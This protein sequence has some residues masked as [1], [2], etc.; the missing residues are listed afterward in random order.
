M[1]CECY[2]GVFFDRLCS[3]ILEMF[4]PFW[5]QRWS[6]PSGGAE[7]GKMGEQILLIMPEF[8]PIG[9]NYIYNSDVGSQKTTTGDLKL[10]QLTPISQYVKYYCRRYLV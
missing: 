5:T 4:G 8:H 9:L 10:C 3:M 6:N 1:I 2:C 7:G